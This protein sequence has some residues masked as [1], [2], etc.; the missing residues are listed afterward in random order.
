MGMM[1]R[2]NVKARG[3]SAPQPDV[4][5]TDTLDYE[6][7]LGEKV[8]NSG[9]RRT[10]INRMTT[11]ELHEVAKGFGV[12]DADEMSGNQIKRTLIAALED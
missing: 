11:A 9:L 10:E 12:E 7:T 1:T 5:V 4:V 2:R 6:E 8:R 3:A